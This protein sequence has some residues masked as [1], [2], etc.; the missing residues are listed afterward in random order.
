MFFLLIFALQ[1]CST[2]N[3]DIHHAV[4]TRDYVRLFNA[5]EGGYIDEATSESAKNASTAGQPSQESQFFDK[6]LNKAVLGYNLDPANLPNYTIDSTIWLVPVVTTFYNSAICGLSTVKRS[7]LNFI[8]AGEN[9]TKV[10]LSLATDQLLLRVYAN[11]SALFMECS[12]KI[13]VQVTTVSFLVELTEL[14]KGL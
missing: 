11:V 8:K 10:R 9:G 4:P 5:E 1:M 2:I 13:L 12:M 7:G 14:H 3:G 6:L